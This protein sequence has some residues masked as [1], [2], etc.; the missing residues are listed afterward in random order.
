MKRAVQDSTYLYQINSTMAL[1]ITNLSL[2]AIQTEFGGSN[3]ISLSEYYRGGANVAT[4][5][6]DS[7]YGL[8]ATSGPIS[9]STF[10]NQ[11][12]VYVFNATISANTQNYNLRAAAVTAGW[13]QARPLIATVTINNGIVVGSSSTATYGFDTG[14][15]FPSGSTLALTIG[16]GAYIVGRGGAGGPGVNSGAG[17]GGS[18]GPAL[19]AQQAI[20]ITN[21]GTIGGGGGGGTGGAA[22]TNNGGGGGGGAGNT[23][24]TAGATPPGGGAAA[25][26]TLTAGGGGGTGAEPDGKGGYTSNGFNGG[27]GG[28]LGNPGLAGTGN[29]A[30]SSGGAAVVGNS[31]ITWV[32]TGTRLGSIS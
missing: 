15:T 10:R 29:A 16:T 18:G 5:Q 32:S 24:G 28:S 14:V 27:A 4:Q 26:G 12:K 3:P 31:N 1:P 9:L 8:I 13:D 25:A 2:S 6:I 11:T 30:V 19:R 20:S 22:G 7:G 17:V 23:V 21:N